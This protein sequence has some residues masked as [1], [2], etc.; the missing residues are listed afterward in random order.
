MRV[1][2]SVKSAGGTPGASARH[3]DY[4]SLIQSL[5]P[6]DAPTLFGLP[7]NSDRAVQQ[8]VRQPTPVFSAF[9]VP[10]STTTPSL[11]D[12]RASFTRISASA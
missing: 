2:D 6:Q 8:R 12:W 3:A 4:A 11:L 10:R 5:A 7:P 1:V 9:L